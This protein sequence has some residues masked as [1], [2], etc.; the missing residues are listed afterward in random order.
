MEVS[1]IHCAKVFSARQV[2]I[3]RGGGKF[4]S[5]AC[6]A[7]N[8]KGK[9][10]NNPNSVCPVCNKSFYRSARKKKLRKS[11]L[12]FCGRKCRE[13]AQKINT[14]SSIPAIFPDHYGTGAFLDYR[15]KCFANNPHECNICGYHKVVQVLQ[16]HHK[17]RNRANNNLDNLQ[18]LCPTCHAEEHFTQKDG[19]WW[20]VK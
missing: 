7:A 13:L 12:S 19:L 3:N 15:E 20:N 16:V 17:D 9:T 10:R 4:C 8:K 1:C 11:G 2:D 18:L 5:L 14:E 6:S